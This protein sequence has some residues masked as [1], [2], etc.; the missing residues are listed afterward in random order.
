MNRELKRL[1]LVVLLMFLALFVASS[2][3]QVGYA[4]QLNADSR[5]TRAVNDSY[6]V[7]RGAIIVGGKPIAQSVRSDDRYQWQRQYSDGP[8]YSAVTGYLAVNGSAT[9]IEGAMNQQ[10]SGTSNADFFQRVKNIIT[11]K[12]P[13]G[14]SVE[15]TIDPVA[16]K[17]AYE[18]LGDKRGAVV[19]EEVGTGKILAMVSKP[20]FDPNKLATHDSAAYT[21]TY[22]AL[23]DADGEPLVNKAITDLNPPG[24]T[25]KPVVSTAAFETGRFT[26]SSQLP[27]PSALQLPGSSTVIH[28]DTGA[29]CQGDTGGNV[30]IQN[31]QVWS[32][33]I[34]FAELGAKLGSSTIKSQAEAFGFN[35]Q[36][37]IPMRVSVSKYPGYDDQA[38][39]MQSAFGQQSDTATALQICMDSAAIANDGV[40]MEPNLVQ[41]VITPDLDRQQEFDPQQFGRAMSADTAK[42]VTG[43]MVKGVDQGTGTNAKIS[44]VSVAGKTGTAQNGDDKP[45]TLWF[46][47][48]APADDPKF[49]V[50]VVVE[51]G[52]GLGQSGS[53]NSVAAPIA[54]Q[55]LEAVLN[56]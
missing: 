39:L 42:T 29:K 12:H 38:E 43:M 46:T 4:D 24:S 7:Q 36:F 45:Y 9:G 1:S 44:G 34:P 50:S 54:R 37:S 26:P 23:Q 32:C 40:V 3:I 25:F 5:N 10:L 31:A 2:T 56:K 55:V 33:N 20:D 47:G 48:F 16:Q 51:D 53:G 41:S 14:N 19:V 27:N 11:G 18:A 28:N 6:N 13:Q 35:H 52:G 15:L 17:A 8:L 21:Q 30:S 49:A 22:D